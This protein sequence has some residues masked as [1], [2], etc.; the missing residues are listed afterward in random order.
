MGRGGRLVFSAI[1]DGSGDQSVMLSVTPLA[2]GVNY[3]LTVEGVTDESA[4]A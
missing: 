2:E 3:T 4:M 1:L